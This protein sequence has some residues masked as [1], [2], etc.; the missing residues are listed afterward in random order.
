MVLPFF[1]GRLG[2]IG[3]GEKAGKRVPCAKQAPRPQPPCLFPI[4]AV[5]LIIQTVL[6]GHGHRLLLRKGE[7]RVGNQ[8]FGCVGQTTFVGRKITIHQHQGRND[9]HRESVDIYPGQA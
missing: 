4:T 8:E 3:A 2:N 6:G 1:F 5:L 9:K 7:L